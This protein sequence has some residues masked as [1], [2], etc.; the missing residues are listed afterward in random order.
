MSIGIHIRHW[1]V[2]EQSLLGMYQPDD[3]T[4]LEFEGMEYLLAANEGDAKEY[5]GIGLQTD[6]TEA[7]R[8]RDI[9]EGKKKHIY[10][11]KISS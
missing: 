9:V 10:C 11:K 8:G 2:G 6:W 3:M 5:E 4:L 7:M 1:G